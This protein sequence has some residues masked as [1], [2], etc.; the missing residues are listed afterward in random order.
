MIFKVEMYLTIVKRIFVLNF[1]SKFMADKIIVQISKQFKM[2]KKFIIIF[3]VKWIIWIIKGDN[4]INF[5]D[6]EC[7]NI[8]KSKI[9]N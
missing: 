4:L 8:I 5:H 1:S 9:H 6:K 3:C 2:N 7:I